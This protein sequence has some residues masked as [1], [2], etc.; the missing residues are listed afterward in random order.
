AAAREPMLRLKTML[1][2]AAVAKGVWQIVQDLKV[3]LVVIWSQTGAT[4]RIFSKNRFPIP[5]VALSSD[6]RALRRMA[7]H[8][9]V[10]PQE[11]AVPSTMG[12]LVE[13]V[14]R[15]VLEKQYASS[16][17]RIV[18]VAGTSMGTPG[19]MN[20]IVIHTIGE[21]WLATPQ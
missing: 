1:L 21:E 18:I 3:K 5:I 8:Y 20:G 6:H 10:V 13:A 17:D 11:R 19:T 15:L 4:A 14:D 9:G 2:S 12:E 7:L 16:G